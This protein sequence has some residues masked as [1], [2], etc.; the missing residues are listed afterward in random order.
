MRNNMVYI[1]KDKEGSYITPGNFISPTRT[2]QGWHYQ[3][4]ASKNTTGFTFYSNKNTAEKELKYL[5]K[6]GYEF[7]MEYISLKLLKECE[8]NVLLR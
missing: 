1:I 5:K 8:N 2:E 4:I 3:K 7:Y 6:L